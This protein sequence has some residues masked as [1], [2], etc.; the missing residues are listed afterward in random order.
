MVRSG[1]GWCPTRLRRLAQANLLPILGFRGQNTFFNPAASLKSRSQESRDQY[2]DFLRDL[3]SSSS[4]LFP[5][6]YV[7]CLP[8][9][10]HHHQSHNHRRPFIHSFLTILSGGDLWLLVA[11]SNF[12]SPAHSHLPILLPAWRSKYCFVLSN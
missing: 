12:F 5:C 4:H 3:F 8:P 1:R 6:L 7:C 2:R 9:P 11:H 10:T